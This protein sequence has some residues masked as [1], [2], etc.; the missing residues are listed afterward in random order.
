MKL[1]HFVLVHIFNK[2]N[3]ILL[4]QVAFNLTAATSCRSTAATGINLTQSTTS[5]RW[6]SLHQSD[7]REVR[8][9][10]DLSFSLCN[11][12]IQDIG[13]FPEITV[14]VKITY[15]TQ[16]LQFTTL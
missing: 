2:A 16:R 10:H 14:I 8:S 7:T 5:V 9:E 4:R 1:I 6:N 3:A 15:I 13:G 11:I 12:S